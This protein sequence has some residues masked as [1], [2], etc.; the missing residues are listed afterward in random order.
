MGLIFNQFQTED[1]PVTLEE[2]EHKFSLKYLCT[3]D[4]GIISIG[5][6]YDDLLTVWIDGDTLRIKPKN[7]DG[8]FESIIDIFRFLYKRVE[9]DPSISKK[10]LDLITLNISER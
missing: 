7:V 1:N 8:V 10:K 4:A 5:T 9:K 3:V 6:L 2:I